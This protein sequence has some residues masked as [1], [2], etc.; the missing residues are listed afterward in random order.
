[1][2]TLP[3]GIR[4]NKEAVA[5]TVEN[6]VRKLIID[7]S[8][9]NPRYYEKMSEL[10]DALIKQRRA[11]AIS[12]EEY[13]L[14]IVE[15]TRKAKNPAVGGA[16][17]PA[18]NTPARKALYDNLGRNEAFALQVDAAV[19]AFRQDD[20][21]NNIFKVKKLRGAVWTAFEMFKKETGSYP[22]LGRDSQ[23]GKPADMIEELVDETMSLV[24]NQNEY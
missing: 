14:K 11:E 8:P 4:K 15:L 23:T 19:R 6:N 7:E 3:E 16:Y 17:P 5:E 24:R 21:R 13:L 10:L 1:M 9:I 2:K 20:W 22:L 18:L 12:Y